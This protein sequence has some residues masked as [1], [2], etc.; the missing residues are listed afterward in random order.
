M[1]AY[2]ATNQKFNEFDEKFLCANDE[3][4]FGKGFYFVD[5]MADADEIAAQ[6]NSSII[7]EC[8][9]SDNLFVLDLASEEE[10][11][12]SMPCNDKTRATLLEV[13]DIEGTAF[14]LGAAQGAGIEEEIEKAGYKGVKVLN[15]FENR[16]YTEIVIFHASDIKITSAVEVD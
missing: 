15:R 3:G 10:T 13:F 7:L 8:E 2:H 6:S 12:K 9:I 11:L 4:F 1:K 16:S 5:D 14:L